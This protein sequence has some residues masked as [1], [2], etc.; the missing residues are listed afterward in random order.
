L[1]LVCVALAAT[2]AA[3]YY[4]VLHHDFL[5]YDDQQ[6]V[7]E[8]PHVRAGLTWAGFKWAFGFHAA[9]W[10]PLTWL[11]HMLDCQLYG[12]TPAG[13]HA[14]NVALH[15]LATVIFFLALHKMTGT[16]WRSAC[17]GGLFAWHPAH[18][19]SVAWVAERKDVLSAFF[20]MLAL[21]GYTHYAAALR[22]QEM[23]VQTSG[24]K[25]PKV[26]ALGRYAA[27]LVLFALGL[28]SKPMVVTF[29]LVLL[30]LDFW[31]LKRFEGVVGA[32]KL[33]LVEK[34]PL[35]L[36][37]IGA[38]LLT[39]Q[40]QQP[41]MVPSKSLPILNRLGHAAMAYVHYLGML[42]WPRKLAIYYPYESVSS[43]APVLWCGLAL[44]AVVA[45]VLVQI[46]KR[47]YLFTGWFWFLGTLVPAIGLVQVGE[48]AW[49]DRYT[50]LPSI[51]LFIAVVWGAW[52]LI[53]T[54]ALTTG[55]QRLATGVA[56]A[57]GTVTMIA[58]IT[59]SARQLPYWRNSR[60]LFTHA[61]DVVPNNYMAVALL[62]SLLEKEG[63][64]AEA[65]TYYQR[66]LQIKPGYPEA[67]FFQAHALEQEG[68][69]GEAI[70]MYRLIL[71]YKPMQEQ[72]RLFLGGA[73]AKA[74]RFDEA[75]AE[76]RT[77]LQSNPDSAIAHN[78][79][80]RAL[81][82][83]GNLEPA[84]AEYE[85]ALRC[86]PQMAEAHNNLGVLLMQA[87]KPDKGI[88]HLRE[89][90]RL[91]PGDGETKFNLAV[92][93]G[94][95]G[96]WAEA[97]KFFKET[98]RTSTKDANAHFQYGKALEGTGETRAAMGE[99]AVALLLRP[100]FPDALNR[101]SWILSTS[102]NGQFRNGPEA[103]RMAARACE[104]TGQKDP[105]KLATLAAA[106]AEVGRFDEAMASMKTALGLIGEAS[107]QAEKFTA[108]LK[109]FESG[110]P[111]RVEK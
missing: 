101:L 58:L 38:C 26:G 60:T 48:Q 99:F 39:L 62:G 92:A 69:L 103:V 7:T 59:V 9:N 19:E 56:A 40:A 1:V 44:I 43:L 110:K 51:G 35:L 49:A 65:L 16:L 10:H 27:V 31:P 30:L 82:A 81:Q 72:I 52:E 13:H 2:A 108:L 94:E 14:T 25:L 64:T 21:W 86:D 28:M 97:E 61:A 87:G 17:V 74:G 11:S 22:G 111:W 102:N 24:F 20:W 90:R 18:V 83:T 45:L 29:P 78:N 105:E 76:A 106:Y 53:Q 47:G 68:R 36:L 3:L 96:Q 54:A 4:P 57:L 55:R 67:M 42:F 71:P 23:K 41:A 6:Y 33:L 34:V 88:M 73:L 37:T 107:P 15:T 84:R 50:Y 89:A 93:L 95:A 75:M 77:V 8:N 66:A 12:V 98:V 85:A 63:H 79:L 32:P 80:G 104:L 70:A 100:D 46:R 109:Q 5:V 91:K